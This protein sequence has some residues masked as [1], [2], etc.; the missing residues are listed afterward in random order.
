MG[1]M[2]NFV[3]QDLGLVFLAQLIE[4]FRE[5]LDNIMGASVLKPPA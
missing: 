3:D 5:D 1:N 4:P 2:H